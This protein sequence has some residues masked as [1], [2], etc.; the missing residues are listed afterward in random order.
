MATSDSKLTPA[1]RAAVEAETIAKVVEWL[2]V[3]AGN[4]RR[5]PYESRERAEAMVLSAR[6][7]QDSANAI[8]RGE[9]KR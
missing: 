6:E 2:R 9:W 5:Y 7:F 4:M 3:R 8:E 1:E